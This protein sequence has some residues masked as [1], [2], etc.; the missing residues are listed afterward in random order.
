VIAQFAVPQPVM[1]LLSQF[2]F[3]RLRPMIALGLLLLTAL[4][5]FP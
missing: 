2:S 3:F 5:S 4:E 1:V